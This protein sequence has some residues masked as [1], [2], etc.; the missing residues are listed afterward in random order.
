MYRCQEDSHIH[1][2]VTW[3]L[4]ALHKP[5]VGSIAIVNHDSDRDLIWTR[6]AP[7]LHII[8]CTLDTS[9]VNTCTPLDNCCINYSTST[10]SQ[11]I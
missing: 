2:L 9:N 11:Q 6:I 8:M 5:L 4:A 7:R 3:S 10:C 1:S